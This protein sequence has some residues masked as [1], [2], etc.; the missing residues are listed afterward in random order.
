MGDNEELRALCAEDLDDARTFR[1]DEAF[2]ASQARRGRVEELIAAGALATAADYYHAARVLQHGER[3][4]HWWRAHE[5]ARTA[6]ALGHPQA[7]YQAAA[8]LDRWLMRGGRP[9]K[10]GTNSVIDGDRWRVWDHDPA[11]TDA[12]RAAW[13]VPPLA[14]LL[15]RG[16][17]AFGGLSVREVCAGPF[18]TVEVGGLRIEILDR[19]DA[20]LP[21]SGP[22]AS[23]PRYE[24]FRAGDDL[25]PDPLPPG[26]VPWRYGTLACATVRDGIPRCSWHRCAWRVR[27]AP[28]GTGEAIF[29]ELGRVPQ[30][31][32]SGARYWSR[33]AVATGPDTCWVVGGQ[34]PAATLAQLA[35]ALP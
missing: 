27:D 12:E 3:L 32:D 34:L 8:A 33:L 14:E 31:L 10:Y 2:V 16:A 23:G 22:L 13:D 18:A 26:L 11:T 30:P 24:P 28:I 15:A 5:L 17:R 9:Q 25:R 35:A 1:G 7:R 21:A 4:A 20:A 6:A 29:A 19:A